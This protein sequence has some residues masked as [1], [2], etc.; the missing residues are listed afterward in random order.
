[1]SELTELPNSTYL[2]HSY[3]HVVVNVLATPALEAVAFSPVVVVI[4]AVVESDRKR[5]RY[6]GSSDYFYCYFLIL[7][8]HPW[9]HGGIARRD[10]AGCMFLRAML[11]GMNP[12]DLDD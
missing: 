10:L 8:Q 9:M 3:V 1:M 12:G 4:V 2:V 7:G 6:N 11:G 5:F